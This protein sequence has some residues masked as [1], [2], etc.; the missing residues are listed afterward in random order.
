M[1]DGQYS[2]YDVVVFM[3]GVVCVKEMGYCTKQKHRSNT[4]TKKH[5]K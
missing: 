1:A 2:G 4:I 5:Q 3:M